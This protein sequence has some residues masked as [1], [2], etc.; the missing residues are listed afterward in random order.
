MGRKN[1]LRDVAARVA[2]FNREGSTVKQQH[3]AEFAF[4]HVLVI[5]KQGRSSTVIVEKSRNV[6]TLS[7]GFTGE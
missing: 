7:S 2:I 4:L 6:N 5:R 3:F 1:D